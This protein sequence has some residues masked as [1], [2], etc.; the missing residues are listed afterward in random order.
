MKNII[1]SGFYKHIDFNIDYDFYEPYEVKQYDTHSRGLYVQIIQNGLVIAPSASNSLTFF[2]VKPD[3]TEIFVDAVI[4]NGLFRVDFPNQ[5]LSVAGEMKGELAL[6]GANNEV[7]TKS[8]TVI[9]EPS[10]ELQGVESTDDFSALQQ[11][12]SQIAGFA[13]DIQDVQLFAENIERAIGN[14]EE[15]TTDEKESIVNSI[16]ELND[17]INDVLGS[18]SLETLLNTKVDKETLPIVY[19]D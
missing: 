7:I 14:M 17:K 15:L 2:A 6:R 1:W 13:G 16:N 8:I 10:L 5:A 12:L 9:I 11:A 18:E 3:G 4:E 19:H